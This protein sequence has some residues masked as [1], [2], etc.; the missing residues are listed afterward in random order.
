MSQPAR[1]CKSQAR[2]PLEKGSPAGRTLACHFHVVITVFLNKSPYH[3]HSLWPIAHSRHYKRSTLWET[4]SKE[5]AHGNKSQFLTQLP[6]TVPLSS[7]GNHQNQVTF[8][9]APVRYQVTRKVIHLTN[10]DIHDAS[11]LPN[12]H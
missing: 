4:Q 11:Q 1:Q 9:L 3:R 5:C 7:K 8:H 12:F 6:M 2:Q 10:D